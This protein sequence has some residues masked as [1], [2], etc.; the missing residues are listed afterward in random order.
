MYTI[1]RFFLHFSS[2]ML[3][4]MIRLDTIQTYYTSADFTVRREEKCKGKAAKPAMAVLW[5]V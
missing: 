3:A 5:T 1:Y 2:I 4:K